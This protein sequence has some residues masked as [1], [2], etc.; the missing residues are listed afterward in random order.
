MNIFSTFNLCFHFLVLHILYCNLAAKVMQNLVLGNV[1]YLFFN[2]KGVS[3][4]KI[5]IFDPK[6]KHYRFISFIIRLWILDILTT[7]TGSM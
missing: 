3:I 1:F 4:E 7:K 6:T 5:I 2:K